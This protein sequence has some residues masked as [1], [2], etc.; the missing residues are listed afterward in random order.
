MSFKNHMCKKFNKLYKFWY[1]LVDMDCEICGVTACTAQSEVC[2]RKWMNHIQI[3]EFLDLVIWLRIIMLPLW[4]CWHGWQSSF[5]SRYVTNLMNNKFDSVKSIWL[6]E[7]ETVISVGKI[8][9]YLMHYSLQKCKS[10]GTKIIALVLPI[11]RAWLLLTIIAIMIK[12]GSVTS[13]L[14]SI[15]DFKVMRAGLE[16]AL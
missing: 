12:N 14:V 2:M 15:S 1:F 11:G 3:N 4:P 13:W 16:I 7:N 10:H 5:H 9:P 8:A 6:F